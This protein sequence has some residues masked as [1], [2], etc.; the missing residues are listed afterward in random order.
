MNFYWSVYEALEEETLAL[1]DN[2]LF[3]DKQLDV[4]SVKIGNLIVRCAVEIEALS[5]ELYCSLGGEFMIFDE[6][7]SKNR[8]P[9]FDT[10]CLD[11]LVKKWRIDKKKIQ[12]VSSKMYFNQDN[13]LLTPLHKSN[14]ARD[15]GSLWNKAYQALKHNRTQSME[16][17]TVRNLLNA[18]EALYILNLYYRNDSFWQNVPIESKEEYRTHSKIFSPFIYEVPGTLLESDENLKARTDTPFDECIYLKKYTDESA[19]K[20]LEFIYGLNLDFLLQTITS[21]EFLKYKQ[22]YPDEQKIDNLI[23][24]IKSIGL[25]FSEMLRKS[26]SSITPPEV[27]VYRRKEIVLNKHQ[28]I[29][30]S[31][32]Y[33]DFLE[34]PK[35]KKM[36]EDRIRELNERLRS[37]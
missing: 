30:S 15:K 16:K 22:E 12:I 29:Y 17:A 14:R 10:E 3:N 6:E 23:D 9:Y 32:E 5:K 13:S 25:D 26:R 20:I 4:Y 11:L 21:D 18:L 24:F 19:N 7:K 27:E 2:I 31:C 35:A 28:Q 36:Q 1:A 37:L 8:Y 33:K 34:T